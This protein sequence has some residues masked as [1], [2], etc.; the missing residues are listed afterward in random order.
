[1]D[2]MEKGVIHNSYEANNLSASPTVKDFHKSLAWYHDVI[3]FA[4]NK[5]YELEGKL[6]TVPLNAGTV[7]LLITQDDG[8]KGLDRLNAE[9]FSL[10]IITDQ[11]IWT[12]G[13]RI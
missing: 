5:N 10:Q 6:F 9:R 2:N 8:A 4:V 3:G 1:M 7:R 12:F 11:N 13:N